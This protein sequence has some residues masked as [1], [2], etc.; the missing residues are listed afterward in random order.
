MSLFNLM[1]IGN[2]REKSIDHVS[3]ILTDNSVQRY[4]RQ[5]TN[6]NDIISYYTSLVSKKNQNDSGQ[7]KLETFAQKKLLSPN[8]ITELLNKYW[9]ETIFLSLSNLSFDYYTNQLKLD[10]LV[11]DQNQYKKFLSDFNKALINGRIEFSES[12]I[13]INKDVHSVKYV[14]RKGFNFGFPKIFPS[15]KLN[16][17][18]I[19]FPTKIQLSLIEKL[20]ENGFPIFSVINGFNQIVVAEPSDELLRNTNSSLIDVIYQWYYNTFLW[21]KDLMPIYEGLFFIN[22]KD[23][24]EY[25][26]YIEQQYQHSSKQNNLKI[27]TGSLDFYYKTAR[28]SPPKVEFRLIPDLKEL[29]QLIYNYR[30]K[31]NI[32]FHRKQLYGKDYFQGQPIYFIQ[33]CFAKNKKTKKVDLIKY[34]YQI[35][36]YQPKKEYQA[37]FMNYDTAIMAWEKFKNQASGYN[38]PNIPKI[39]VYNLEDFLKT[40][41]H[42]NEI[43]D[44]HL[45]FIPSQETYNFCKQE[46]IKKSPFSIPKTLSSKILYMKVLTTRI[47]WSLTSRQPMHW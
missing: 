41:E 42:D 9:Q 22:P 33:P 37:I 28:V 2:I 20:Q 32:S 10:G 29:S 27:F 6:S 26:R 7:K 11:I 14:W 34:S 35:S 16:K 40:C 15:I 19:G 3:H 8:F 36:S 43:Q 25:M 45:L 44:K 47:L 1:F 39:V 18:Y 23:A 30:H 17:R 38:L 24:S 4:G 21:Q 12:I 46:K 31:K 5:N 13:K